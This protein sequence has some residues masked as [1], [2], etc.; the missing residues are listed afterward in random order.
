MNDPIQ[1]LKQT[2][3][4]QQKPDT[5]LDVKQLRIIRAYLNNQ[6][7]NLLEFAKRHGFAMKSGK[8]NVRVWVT[9]ENTH[10]LHSRL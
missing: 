3:E 8:G 9:D 7:E 5:N 2:P 4:L 1:E 10:F 6:L